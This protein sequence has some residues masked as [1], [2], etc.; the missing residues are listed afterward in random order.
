MIIMRLRDRLAIEKKHSTRLKGAF[1]LKGWE[2]NAPNNTFSKEQKTAYF[3]ENYLIFHFEIHASSP[4]FRT[5]HRIKL[6]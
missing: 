4:K 6:T 3:Y 5:H 1:L 2:Y